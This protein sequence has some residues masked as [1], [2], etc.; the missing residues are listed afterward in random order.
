VFLH[1]QRNLMP[2]LGQHADGA[3]KRLDVLLLFEDE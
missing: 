2:A 1:S 3:G